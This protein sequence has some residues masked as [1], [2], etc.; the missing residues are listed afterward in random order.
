MSSYAGG[1]LVLVL[2]L[3]L[4]LNLPNTI[5]YFE[6]GELPFS[7]SFPSNMKYDPERYLLSANDFRL[8][9]GTFKEQEKII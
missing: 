4:D 2:V 5:M 1:E 9:T 3:V 7:G 8:V 6:L